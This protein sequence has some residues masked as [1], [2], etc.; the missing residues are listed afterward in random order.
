MTFLTV[1][2]L[3]QVIVI[4]LADAEV[5]VDAFEVELGVGVELVMG[6]GDEVAKGEGEA[7]GDGVGDGVTTGV[8]AS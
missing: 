8:G 7:L 1:L 5:A 6:S 2:P 4:F 3:T